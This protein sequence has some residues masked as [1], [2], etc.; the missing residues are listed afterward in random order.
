MTADFSG[1]HSRARA[2]STN[3]NLRGAGAN[4]TTPSPADPMGLIEF[5][6]TLMRMLARLKRAIAPRQVA[7][8]FSARK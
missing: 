4:A 6:S 7:V 1:P 5:G 8:D 3:I 2:C